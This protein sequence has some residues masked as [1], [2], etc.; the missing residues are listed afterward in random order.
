MFSSRHKLY[1]HVFAVINSSNETV[2]VGQALTECQDQRAFNLVLDCFLE[3]ARGT[4]PVAIFTDHDMAM[5]AA[6][7]Y[8]MGLPTKHYLCAWH[9]A[10]NVQRH[11][12]AQCKPQFRRVMD[13]FWAC[14]RAFDEH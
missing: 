5:Q 7:E 10:K 3:R 12:R 13:R 1:L 4:K 6:I 11:V 2:I 8:R 9:V 14:V